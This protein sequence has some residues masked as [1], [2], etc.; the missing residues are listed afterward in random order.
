MPRDESRPGQ[1]S[2]RGRAFGIIQL[3]ADIVV[4]AV[5]V[6]VTIRD[7]NGFIRAIGAAAVV[8]MLLSWFFRWRRWRS[9]T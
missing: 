7:H 9:R 8:I 6:A 4:V 1:S 2:A 3:V 5:L